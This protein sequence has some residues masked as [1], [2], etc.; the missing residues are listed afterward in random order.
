MLDSLRDANEPAKIVVGL[1]QQHPQLSVAGRE[2]VLSQ[3]R[4]TDAFCYLDAVKAI[5]KQL[6]AEGHVQ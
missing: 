2:A 5:E 3:F 4:N 1:L 6:E